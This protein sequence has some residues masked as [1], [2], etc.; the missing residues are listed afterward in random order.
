ML[1]KKGVL[2]TQ[3]IEAMAFCHTDNPN[4]PDLVPDL[5]I[6]FGAVG[7]NGGKPTT[8]VPLGPRNLNLDK[9]GEMTV[10][11]SFVFLPTLLQPKSRGYIELRSRNPFDNP[12][13]VMNYLQEKEDVDVLLKGM[14]ICK[15]IAKAKAYKGV[16][17]NEVVLNESTKYGG[18]DSDEYLTDFIRERA[19]T[20]YHYCGTCKMGE[21]ESSVV[22]SNLK[23]KGISNLRVVDCSVM[24]IVPRANT[25]A[26][27][28]MLAEKAADIIKKDNSQYLKQK[29][30]L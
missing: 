3:V 19:V 6:H 7:G 23:V 15:N 20:V 21:D 27:V 29:A 24:P 28:I 18:I 8:D 10:G 22:N 2:S 16:V 1:R 11:N 30:K 25:N 17:G 12:K 9:M 14:K 13:I 26:P 5:Q 4:N